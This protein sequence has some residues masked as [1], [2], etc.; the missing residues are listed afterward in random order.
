MKLTLQQIREL[1][2]YTFEEVAEYCEVSVNTIKK[3]ERST[4]KLPL[5][6]IIKL[7]YLYR[8]SPN[9]LLIS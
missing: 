3:Y 6:L 9:M 5:Y 8:M 2:G 1:Y 7:S 4:S